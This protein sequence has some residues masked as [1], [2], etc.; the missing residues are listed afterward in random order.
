MR[1]QR[2]GVSTILAAALVAVVLLAAGGA[3]IF[4]SQAGMMTGNSNTSSQTM[5]SSS[6]SS[7][8][9]GSKVVMSIPARAILASADVIANYTMTVVVVGTLDTPLTL[10]AQAPNG[11]TVTF[12]PGS[13]QPGQQ[14]TNVEVSIKV[15][16][17]AQSGSYT[18]NVTASGAGIM[19][20]PGATYAQGFSLHLVPFLVV[21]V[22]TTFVP[23]SITVPAGSTVDWIRLNGAIDQYDNGAHNVVFSN[24]MASSGTMAQYDT[25]SYTFNTPGSFEY[26][27]TFH[28][29]MQGTVVVS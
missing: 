23:D 5:T 3:Y 2:A 15:G 26:D 28:A 13:I 12:Q 27:C 20:N 18:L 25:Y 17:S 29:T 16:G 9:G 8:A 19:G 7:G 14:S 4:Y 10:E 1:L 11:V 21:T 24:G 22:G 6:S